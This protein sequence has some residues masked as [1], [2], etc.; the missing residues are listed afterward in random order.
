MSFLID[1][2]ITIIFYITIIIGFDL[3]IEVNN[4]YNNNNN[5]KIKILKKK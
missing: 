3:L 4:N 1:S 5:N 2:L